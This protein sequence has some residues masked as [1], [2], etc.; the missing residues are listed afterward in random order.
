MLLSKNPDINIKNNEGDTPLHK[1][2]KSGN[3][4]IVS[5]LIIAGADISSYNNSFKTPIDIARE[6]NNIT[7]LQILEE[8][9]N[10]KIN[11][12]NYY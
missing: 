9:H 7:I 8:K 6:N 1:A 5:E 3:I 10:S 2:V 12:P 11:E 4:D